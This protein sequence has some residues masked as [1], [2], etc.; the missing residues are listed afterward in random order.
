[1]PQT[2]NRAV[3]NWLFTFAFIV[4]FL[5]VFG[6]FVRLTRSGLSIVEWN[7]ISGVMPPIGEKA[8]IEEF[9]KY[10]ATPEY[11]LINTGMTLGEYK[12]IFYMEWIHRMIARL[13][14][15]VYAIP[16][17]Y[18]LYKK[19]IPWKEFGLY[20]LMGILFI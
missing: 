16:V 3:M 5:V 1:M 20:F 17:F 12:F 8:W 15:L 4:A 6:G 13:A 2:Q 11:K 19:S 18:F 7:P 14:G 9:T 10:Q